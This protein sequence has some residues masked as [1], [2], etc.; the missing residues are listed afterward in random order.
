MIVSKR[1]LA[2]HLGLSLHQITYIWPKWQAMPDFPGP[3]RGYRA[4]Y[5]TESFDRFLSARN[6][7]AAHTAATSSR[8]AAAAATL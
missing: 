4:K 7:P 6:E 2:A 8:L 5:E 3:V 1:Q